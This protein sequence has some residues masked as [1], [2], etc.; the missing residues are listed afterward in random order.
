MPIYVRSKRSAPQ[1]QPAP[2]AAST[3]KGEL[4]FGLPQPPAGWQQK[5]PGISLCM[6]VKNEELFLAQCLRS[7]QDVVDEII[8]VDTGSTDRTI[9]I[10]KSF[11][12]TVLERPWRDDFGWARNQALEAATKRWMLVLDADEELMVASKPSLTALKNVPSYLTAVWVRI[13]NKSDDYVGTGDMS[14]ALVRIFPNDESIR[15]RGLIHEFPTV[16][17]DPNGL[18]AASSPIGVIHHGYVKEIVHARGKG[19]RNLA[20]VKAAADREPDDPYNWFNVG[21]TAFLLQDFETARDA[22]EKMLVLMG[23]Q[24]RGY[25]PNGLAILAETYCDK[26]DDPIKGEEVARRGL[27]VSPHYANSHFQLGKSLIAQKRFEEGREAYLAAIDD[28]RFAAQQFVVDDQVYL[29]KA[30]SEIGSSYVMQGDDVKAIEWFEKGLKNAPNAEPLHINRARALERLGRVE[31]ACEAFRTIYELHGSASSTV[32]YVNALL[33]RS[34]GADAMAVVDATMGKFS[35]ETSLPLLMAAA[36]V[37]ER[38]GDVARV[39]RFLRA[40]AALQPGNAAVIA[41]LEKLLR[42][43]SRESELVEIFA[44][45]DAAAPE[46]PA[47]YLRRAQRAANDGRFADAL[48]L[49]RAGVE[50]APSDENLR[51]ALAY[52]TWQTGDDAGSLQLLDTIDPSGNDLLK[53]REALRSAIY[54]KQGRLDDAILALDALLAVDPNHVDSML[55]RASILETQGRFD[56]QEATLRRAHERDPQRSAVALSSFY[57]RMGRF[58]D[59]ARIAGQAIQ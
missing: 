3:K 29:W 37:A 17:G 9:E 57:L 56:E 59:A 16:N 12:A 4:L 58:E 31:E 44:R 23:D 51:Y 11:G 22:L 50:R 49:A 39:E 54:R 18:A 28:G 35:G 7:V 32:E 33:R 34:R 55:L 52:S 13:Y 21:A 20:I 5:P 36:A 26:L 6:I 19:A 1:S 2:R 42:A 27:A 24:R 10:A 25:L 45:E 53:A 48:A 40:A 47:D 8:V 41:P 38:D 15:Y 43:A 30:H 46:T 14:H